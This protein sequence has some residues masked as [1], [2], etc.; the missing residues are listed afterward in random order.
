M[1]NI[2]SSLDSKIQYLS[3]EFMTDQVV[4]REKTRFVTAIWGHHIKKEN[5]I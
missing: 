3:H 5:C 4:F 1:E 2:L